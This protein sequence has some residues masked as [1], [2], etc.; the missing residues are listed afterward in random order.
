MGVLR[1]KRAGELAQGDLQYG[2]GKCR[3][4]VGQRHRDERFLRHQRGRELEGAG[5]SGQTLHEH[6]V[7]I[8]AS[9]PVRTLGVTAA[10]QDLLDEPKRP[11]DL[12]R[13]LVVFD[14]D[15]QVPEV[16]LVGVTYRRGAVD[17][18]DG[19]HAET[20]AQLRQCARQI[21]ARLDVR[22]QGDEHAH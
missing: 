17:G 10:A 19:P 8:N 13:R 9:R 12:L 22:A 7:E 15:R 16:G 5:A 2:V 21:L 14:L 4:K 18:G 3:C 6:Q 1:H 11:L 20:A